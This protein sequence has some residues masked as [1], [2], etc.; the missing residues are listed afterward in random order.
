MIMYRC[1]SLCK[2]V[3][4]WHVNVQFIYEIGEK[5][6]FYYT[7]KCS[8]AHLYLSAVQMLLLPWQLKFE[9]RSLN[10][11]DQV[12]DLTVINTLS[13]SNILHHFWTRSPEIKYCIEIK[14]PALI[15][16]KTALTLEMYNNLFMLMLSIIHNFKLPSI[17][18]KILKKRSLSNLLK[19]NLVNIH[20]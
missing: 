12:D 10:F 11:N 5:D 4:I 20:W 17:K 15:I 9:L 13:L 6:N 2:L 14:N 1:I 3:R 19:G 16:E 7:V 8:T 18:K